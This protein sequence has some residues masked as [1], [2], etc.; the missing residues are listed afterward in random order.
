MA[1]VEVQTI[2]RTR[3]VT[4]NRPHRRNAVDGPT[5]GA[6]RRGVPR[7][8]TPTT[9]STSRCSPGA[10][11]R[12]LRGRGPPGDRRGQGQPGRGRRRRADGA[13]AAAAHQARPRGHRGVRGRRRARARAAGATCASR[14]S[15]PCSGV[16]CR[17]FGVPLVDLGT[18]RLPRLIGHSRA[19]GPDPHGP[20]RR[21]HRGARDGPRE[22]GGARRR[23][24]ST[25]RSRSPTS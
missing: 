12:L 10:D 9:R 21:R 7:P 24:H 2:G 6:A 3:V 17:R 25:P 18:I 22:P 5:R 20:R 13:D 1:D 8:S 14:A 23:R 15:T 16:F 19:I 4:I 11:G